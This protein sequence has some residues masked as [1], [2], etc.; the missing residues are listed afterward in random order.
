MK[1]ISPLW[2]GAIRSKDA[3]LQLLLIVDYIFDW[4]RDSQREAILNE[5]RIFAGRNVDSVVA[6]SDV[7]S[8]NDRVQQF[9]DGDMQHGLTG[10]QPNQ[11][12]LDPNQEGSPYRWLDTNRIVIRS[13]SR[14]Y[15]RVSALYI[16]RANIK[17]LL[18]SFRA[19]QAAQ[20]F[21]RD[22]L[23]LFREAWKVSPEALEAL[24]FMWTG[25]QREEDFDVDGT[26]RTFCAVFTVSAYFRK[27]WEHTVELTYIAIAVDVLDHLKSFVD[28]QQP[29]H[30][31][32]SQ[33]PTVRQEHLVG[34]L[35]HVRQSSARAKLLAAMRGSCL[36]SRLAREKDY[37]DSFFLVSEDR[38]DE[39]VRYRVDVT[40]LPDD[41]PKSRELVQSVHSMCK[42]GMREPKESFLRMS[43]MFDTSTQNDTD[44]HSVWSTEDRP[45]QDGALF[46]LLACGCDSLHR[47]RSCVCVD[48]VYVLDDAAGPRAFPLKI[49]P[50]NSLFRMPRDDSPLGRMNHG[51]EVNSKTVLTGDPQ[52]QFPDL[53]V[54][55]ES[56]GVSDTTVS[57]TSRRSVYHPTAQL[58]PHVRSN[59]RTPQGHFVTLAKSP[60]PYE[61]MRRSADFLVARKYNVKC[62]TCLYTDPQVDGLAGL[63]SETGDFKPISSREEQ[64]ETIRGRKGG[65]YEIANILQMGDRFSSPP[66]TKRSRSAEQRDS[67][68]KTSF[69]YGDWL[70]DKELAGL[71]SAL[72]DGVDLPMNHEICDSVECST[73]AS[74][75]SESDRAP[76]RARL[77]ESLNGHD[78]EPEDTMTPLK[79]SQ[80]SRPEI[81]LAGDHLT[82][83]EFEAFLASGIFEAT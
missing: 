47:T 11:S 49:D 19:D 20:K 1:H 82:D 10:K 30:V 32:S 4:A 51:F 39:G 70:T 56:Q 60:N 9:L 81:A 68:Q 35:R 34:Y 36:S 62:I 25:K 83:E 17:D 53:L 50:Q 26:C 6:D 66:S 78:T 22:L 3:A 52:Q 75:T 54:R 48:C 23:R 63:R 72:E 38:F 21:A 79:L 18:L 69:A 64:Q 46:L 2:A 43:S 59:R 40:M 77:N 15:A 55:P 73:S 57:K 33:L 58:P 67:P 65:H 29:I 74:G 28:L 61:D 80:T 27:D 14:V 37:P 24:E 71:E 13:I 44:Q 31:Y 16:T 76:K 5:L 41:K 45:M 42:K 8:L 7:R 12:D